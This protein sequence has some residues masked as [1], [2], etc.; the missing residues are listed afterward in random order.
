MERIPEVDKAVRLSPA[1]DDVRADASPHRLPADEQLLGRPV[2]DD[3]L[4]YV[5]IGILQDGLLVG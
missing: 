5:S 4:N 1:R 3:L 2:V